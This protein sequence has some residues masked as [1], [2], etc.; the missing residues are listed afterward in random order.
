MSAPGACA[1]NSVTSPV[2][3]VS[4]KSLHHGHATTAPARA[5][6]AGILWMRS[7][8]C[9]QRFA[10]SAVG[11]VLGTALKDSMSRVIVLACCHHFLDDRIGEDADEQG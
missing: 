3:I 1:L 6:A 4:E 8:S 2:S 10:A 9:S 5:S 11:K 7:T